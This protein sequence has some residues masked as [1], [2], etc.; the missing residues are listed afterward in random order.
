MIP[1]KTRISITI[2]GDTAVVRRGTASSVVIARV[3]GV[4]SEGSQEHVYLDRRVHRSEDVC[5]DG[6]LTGGYTTV[7]SRAVCSA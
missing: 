3:L 1:S 5:E 4:E 6:E 7:L 2:S